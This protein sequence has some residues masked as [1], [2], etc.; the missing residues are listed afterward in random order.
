MLPGVSEGRSDPTSL[1]GPA[2]DPGKL[3]VVATTWEAPQPSSAQSPR[4]GQKG[5]CGEAGKLCGL[6]TL[7]A[8]KKPG[9]WTGV[10]Q[11]V[12]A[13]LRR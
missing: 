3:G 4:T 2:G 12:L 1:R 6:R 13:G 7:M 9:S 5:H 8:G 10:G 11:A